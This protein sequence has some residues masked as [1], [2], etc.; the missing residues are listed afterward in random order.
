[1]RALDPDEVL[2][3]SRTEDT[4]VPVLVVL[5]W[6]LLAGGTSI[7]DSASKLMTLRTISGPNIS[8]NVFSLLF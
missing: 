7:V 4:L 3:K 8:A 1:M 5:V 2:A 6:H